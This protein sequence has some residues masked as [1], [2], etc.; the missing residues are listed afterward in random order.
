M[1]IT[2]IP[3]PSISFTDPT[4]ANGTITTQKYAYINTTIINYSNTTAFIDWNNSLV[5]WWRF[6]N[7]IGEN[8]TFFRDWSSWGNNGTCSGTACPVS[9]SGMFGNAL[10]FDGVN[11]YLNAGN[12]S[13]LNVTDATTV[14]AWIYPRADYVGYAAHPISKWS[15]TTDATMV[16]YYFGTTSGA[17]RTVRFY[18]NRGGTWNAISESYKVELNKWYHIALSYNSTKGGQ[19]YVNGVPIGPLTG[20]GKLA[21]NTQPLRIGGG[22]A[23]YFN[24]TIDEVRIH[25]RALSPDEIK[26]SY[27]AGTYRLYRNFTNLTEDVYNYRAYVQNSYGIVNQTETRIL[28]I[29]TPPPP[30][31]C[32]DS[33]GF[34]VNYIIN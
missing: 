26:A 23:D 3:V 32:N 29:T 4:P 6:N 13:S 2:P 25:N 22:S 11:D 21:S 18:A 31:L 15:S 9:M 33:C 24:G 1:N 10:S 20:S 28:N 7:E 16:L 19:L 5:G 34:T 12:S 27:D 8:S 14:E 30:V 17:N